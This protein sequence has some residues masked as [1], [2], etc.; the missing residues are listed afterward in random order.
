MSFSFFM[1]FIRDQLTITLP[2]PSDSYTDQTIIVT[3]GNVGLGFEAA[4]HYV[5]LGAAKVILA[6]RTIEKGEAAK[7]EIETS[8]KRQAVVEVWPLDLSSY[9]SV[10]AFA[11]RADSLPRLDVVLENA[12]IATSEFKV[13]ED[14][15]STITTNVVSTFLLALLILPKLRETATKFNIRPHLTI[16]TSEVHFMTQFPEKSS[17]D[18]FATL[19]DKQ[20]ARMNDR[21]QVSKLLEVFYVRSLASH[22]SQKQSSKPAITINMVNPGLC[23]SELALKSGDPIALKI[24]KF[25]LARTTEEG[26]R[27]YLAATGAGEESHGEYMNACKVEPVARLVTSEVGV[28]TQEKVWEQ[29]NKKLEK[30]QP[31]I[32]GNI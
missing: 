3:G 12:G 24:M 15:E 27:T 16:V 19:N 22:I 2:Y 8:E 20:T 4:R 21:Y 31:G 23:H 14:N 32:V 30:I 18:I 10:K 11:K 1:K 26:S 7:K 25:L 5:R 6:V 29:L 28:E 17:E 13:T 9:D